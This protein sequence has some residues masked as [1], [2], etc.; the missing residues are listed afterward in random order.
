VSQKLYSIGY[1]ST[2]DQ[3][4][5]S[6]SKGF[7][8][9]EFN[10]MYDG[11][12]YKMDNI[13][14]K[15]KADA[16]SPEVFKEALLGNRSLLAQV[17]GDIY[18]YDK[19]GK[20]DRV[21]ANVHIASVPQMLDSRGTFVVRGS[22]YNIIN[23]LRKNSAPYITRG[24]TDTD[25][26]A[27]FNLAKGRNFHIEMNPADSMFYVKIGTSSVVIKALAEVLDI[28]RYDM[29][30][31]IGEDMVKL[32]WDNVSPSL[33]RS[34][35][36]KLY[37]KVFEYKHDN[38]S[39]FTDHELK[40]LL[41]EYFK[42]TVMDPHTT[43][44][45]Y[46]QEMSSV[47]KAALL[48][49]L[50][51]YMKIYKKE[52]APHNQDELYYQRVMTPNLL[53]EDRIH[54][55]APT[56]NNTI[57]FN[58]ARAKSAD[59]YKKVF[60]NIYSKPL[61]SM[62]AGSDLARI[63]PQYNPLGV[64]V[65]PSSITP[66]GMGGVNDS[67]AIRDSQRDIH[68]S[69]M[70]V[71]DPLVSPQGGNVGILL[72]TTD[73]FKVDEK[74]RVHLKV[75]DKKGKVGHTSLA[76]LKDKYLALPDVRPGT[77]KRT[78]S[79]VHDGEIV[80]VSKDK[81]THYFP[82]GPEDTLNSLDRLF[83]MANAVQGN[84]NFMSTR[85]ITQSLPLAY[86]E[87]PYIQTESS[88]GKNMYEKVREDLES[89]MP[90]RS[91]VDGVV[92]SVKDG[93][94][95]IKD[96]D[97]KKHEV[98][99][100]RHLP[101]ATNTGIHQIPTVHRE[102]RVKKRQ[103]IL[104]DNYTVDGKI[105]F[106]VNLKTA[107]M[108]YKGYN[109]EDAVVISET[110]SKKLMSVHYY[111][112]DILTGDENIIGKKSFLNKFPDK[113]Q[114]AQVAN[115]EA[116]G[117]IT[118]NTRINYGDPLVLALAKVLPDESL[119][120][121]GRIS[122]DIVVTLA[123]SSLVYDHHAIGEVVEISERSKVLTVTVKTLERAVVGDKVA[124][125]Y[126]NKGVVSVVIP[127]D[128][129][130]RNEEGD[131]VDVIYAASAVPSRMNPAQI[132]E[133]ALS[134]IVK[135][136]GLKP[137]MFQ[138]LTNPGG[139]PLDEFVEKEMKKHGVSDKEFLID[140]ITGKK[141]DRPVASGQMYT[142]KLLKGDKDAAA[143][144]LGPA[145][146]SNK[147][148]AKGGSEGAKAIGQAEFYALVAHN[149]RATMADFSSIKGQHNA[150]Y[151][152]KSLYGAPPT[153]V[154]ESFAFK[155]FKAN[156][157]SAGSVF[158]ETKDGYQ[159][160]PLTDKV[161]NQLAGHRKVK[162][163]A[164]LRSKTLEPIK[165]GLYDRAITG[166][167]DGTL[168]SKIELEDGMVSPM[169]E[170]YVRILLGMK[171]ADIRKW[172]AEHTTA[173]MRK[174]LNKIDVS[175]RIRELKAKGK[176][177]GKLTN[178]EIKLLRFLQNI[179][180]KGTNLADLIITSLPV[181]PPIYRPM[182]QLGDGSIQMADSNHFYKDI[183][184]ANEGLK[185]VKGL[186][187]VSGEVKDELIYNVHALVGTE[188]TKNRTLAN[189]GTK[190]ILEA[191]GGVGS[192]KYGFV[193]AN[194]VKKNQDLAGRARIIPNADLDMDEVGI[195][196]SMAWELYSPFIKKSLVSSGMTPIDA[197]KAITHKSTPAKRALVSEVDKRPVLINR[198]P[199]LHRFGILSM[200]PRLVSGNSM[201]VSMFHTAP[202]NAD[203][204]G[205]AMQVH[206]PVTQAA[207]REA[208]KMRMSQNLLGDV[209][210]DQLIMALTPETIIG[211]YDKARYDRSTVVRDLKKILP[212]NVS[213]PATYDKKGLKQLSLGIAKS[214][215]ADIAG[216][217]QRV[218][219][220][221]DEYATQS[222]RT[223][224]VEDVS[225]AGM[226]K[227]KDAIL[228]KYK[229]KLS[230]VKMGTP[231]YAVELESAQK[232]VQSLAKKHPGDVGEMLR[233]GAK[234][235]DNQ[236]SGMILS[237]VIAYNPHDPI[238][239]ARMT[240][241][242]YS[243]GLN[244][245]DF[246][247]QV[248]KA[249]TD[250]VSTAMSVAVPGSLAKLMNA[251][252]NKMVISEFDCETM[253]GV[254][255]DPSTDDVRGSLLAEKVGI[256]NRNTIINTLNEAAIS[257][258]KKIKI[259]SPQTCQSTE[260][261]CAR[262]YG[263]DAMGV[264]Y[265]VGVNVGVRVAQGVSEPIAQMAL[266]SKHGGRSITKDIGQGGLTTITNIFSSDATKPGMAIVAK[267]DGTVK[268]TSV[269]PSGAT[270]IK[271]VDGASYTA[272]P[273]VTVKVHEGS[274]VAR[275]DSITS[276]VIPFTDV[277]E[278]KGI[279]AGRA[280][281]AGQ[282][283]ES[284]DEN[285]RHLSTRVHD[286]IGKAA[287]NY[288]TLMADLDSHPAGTTIT[289]S[290]LKQS[291]KDHSYP[292]KLALVTEGMQ[293]GEEFGDLSAGTII[294][295]KEARKIAAAK[296]IP[297]T[298]KKFIRIVENKVPFEWVA[299]TLYT[300]GLADDDWM[301]HIAARYIKKELTSATAEGDV[302]KKKTLS[303]VNVWM[304]GKAMKN[305]PDTPYYE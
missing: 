212:A 305:D 40:T 191:I 66:L 126:G 142:L 85:Q 236:I 153:P 284:L 7:R 208:D 220:L 93:V 286:L 160:L 20:K 206:V 88:T 28:T 281:L 258:N 157:T 14:F 288:V 179:K 46:K 227:E 219:V 96:D 54:K 3:I 57:K 239:T 175:S 53:F 168:W 237:P 16:N 75:R 124:G 146:T 114:P 181:P 254:F 278:A 32:N 33:V 193:H 121:I 138:P 293:L 195:P 106:G 213:L 178:T 246:W 81:I 162:T 295:K 230:R 203:F 247:N 172:Q 183:L 269:L 198:A 298:D 204:D 282:L 39:N 173:E 165:N 35:L 137:Y 232:E 43:K 136:K 210:A 104:K 44:L 164:L 290:Q 155:R 1:G 79:A 123:D 301:H 176:N 99:Y 240:E 45:L 199:T 98:K 130:M 27:T 91:P 171:K 135:K 84:R 11:S 201:Q 244:F 248:A 283:R 148:P 202:F 2:Q 119:M 196:T 86:K 76:S 277:I 4:E 289:Y 185:D 116:N 150:D 47:D 243:E 167:V 161:T 279:V 131:V 22:D 105:A 217:F 259:R 111:K 143:R 158:N 92:E 257:K 186:K 300:A 36:V 25:I 90:L 52:K 42:T 17:H 140:P 71:I 223:V 6:M 68:V 241:S 26:K 112:Y 177:S 242:S 132:H 24:K 218:K 18:R 166:G 235:S 274:S 304:Q 38:P 133:Q 34:N 225:G 15:R 275:G 127:D 221:G 215:A 64:M 192:P 56:I 120:K 12:T 197:A 256:F 29:V 30:K 80:N 129:M 184:I 9:V 31:A 55:T 115:I 287:A 113:F 188:K 48:K 226:R 87:L 110:A 224:G 83:P 134:K 189:K 147:Q 285:G 74:G 37:K 233:A 78:V 194:L 238:R 50:S 261:V 294:T 303:P 266:D 190:S 182:T 234:G 170:D 205:D 145:Y 108:P 149:A 262:C 72:R 63:D 103:I 94:I 209:S 59:D 77:K 271:M 65:T 200:K 89:L 253:D 41:S 272:A 229:K 101:L 60:S 97:G 139:K 118:K 23:Q 250:M 109:A 251:A 107:F 51:E 273:D 159:L 8:N 156:L 299:R 211:F 187:S 13:S 264:L 152:R 19:D 291:L 231:E 5:D 141:T 82:N 297:E 214:G 73:N 58:L 169:I 70:G 216:I 67:M 280:A 154:G 292:K 117:I 296:T 276:G 21:A 252:V 69:S 10:D 61:I 207:I 125:M 222:G 302:S 174:E 49:I 180:D 62:V 255:V 163:P 228:G 245:N 260:G 270:I 102:E 128:K 267:E 122:K 268:S 95:T 151:W 263:A 144:G 249:R 265:K 100:A